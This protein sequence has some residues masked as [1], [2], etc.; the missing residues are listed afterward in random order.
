MGEAVNV[1]ERLGEK[2]QGRRPSKSFD[3]QIWSLKVL[4]IIVRLVPRSL[5]NYNSV[6]SI[7]YTIGESIY[8]LD[9]TSI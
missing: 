5:L 9:F 8:Y 4:G 7:R 1:P 2:S 6:K 3:G